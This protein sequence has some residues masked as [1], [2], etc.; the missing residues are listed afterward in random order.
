MIQSVS[1]QFWECNLIVVLRLTVR[2]WQHWVSGLLHYAEY[3]S[4]TVCCWQLW[5]HDLAVTL[6]WVSVTTQSASGKL[7]VCS[8]LSLSYKVRFRATLYDCLASVSLFMDASIAGKHRVCARPFTSIWV[9]IIL[10]LFGDNFEYLTCYIVLSLRDVSQD[11]SERVICYIVLSLRDVSQDNFDTWL[12]T[13]CWVFA[14]Y[15]R[16]I[17]STWSV[18]S[19]W[20]FAM[21][22]RTI[23]CAW[24]VTSC[25]VFIINV[26]LKNTFKARLLQCVAESMCVP[27]RLAVRVWSTC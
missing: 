17:L 5:E 13:S 18:T 6:C 23:L 4:W 8:V 15:L 1:R 3:S 2:P 11:N 7:W 22:L 9:S 16:T 20:V 24:S 25:W 26:Q 10:C 12:V 14:M 21:S 19:C 27:L